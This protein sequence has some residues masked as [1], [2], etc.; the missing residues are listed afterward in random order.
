MPRNKVALIT[1]G[2]HGVGK[3]I[4]L[5][6]ARD[7]FDVIICGH[8]ESHLASAEKEIESI[9][10]HVHTFQVEA[11]RPED[12]KKLFSEV[13]KKMGGLDVLVNNV[14]RVERF[15]G[16]SDL[17]DDDWRGAYELN[18][19][20]AVYFT[21]EALPW[22]KKS[23]AARIINIASVPARQPGFFNP[24]YSAAKAALV[25][26]SKHLANTLAKDKVL[27]NTICPGA[28]K[29]GIWERNVSDKAKNLGVS[30]AEAEKLMEK[31]EKAKV[32]LQEIG[33]PEDVA[34]LVAFLASEKAKFITGTCIDVDGGTTRS[35]F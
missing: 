17:S 7:G 29:G 10:T 8:T 31:E 12:V 4:A 5:A 26:L 13:V 1:G 14:G 9:G 6:L 18:F 19:M 16:F 23:K 27:V 28:L 15:G 20:S 11:T 30:E 34:E 2:G 35:V 33:M 32:P 24:H 21:R 25:N 22:L 3:A